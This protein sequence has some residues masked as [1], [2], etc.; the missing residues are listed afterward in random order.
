MTGNS[1]FIGRH[2]HA[3]L[4]KKGHTVIGFSIEDGELAEAGAL[5]EI[6]LVDYVYHLAGR[7]VVS[8]SWTKV[9]EYYNTNV[10]GTESVLEY[11][12]RYSVPL[13][14]M[15][16][17]VY[18]TPQYLP[19][20]EKHPI[21][22]VSPYHHSK[23]LGE[24]LCR[25]Y[26]ENFGVSVIIFRAFNV[27]GNGQAATSLVPF[28]LESCLDDRKDTVEV[29]DL[30]PKRDFIYINDVVEAM[31]RALYATKGYRVLNIGSG[32]SIS[33]EEVIKI[34]MKVTGKKKPIT[35]KKQV[36]KNE[37]DDC[38]ADIRYAREVLSFSPRYTFYEG[39]ENW[40]K[41]LRTN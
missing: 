30:S 14:F 12:R 18:G 26:A 35:E 28:V 13:F 34:I 11:C 17:Y 27:F 41:G 22:A 1:G 33:V 32:V 10:M 31:E 6:G 16:T 20:D 19:V 39:M 23:I 37:I 2:L 7:T 36:R 5:D 21:F 29:M 3:H 38:I 4:E 8:E 24:S 15:S 25:F 9:H 40:V